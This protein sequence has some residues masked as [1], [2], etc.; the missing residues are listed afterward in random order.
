[1]LSLIDE[2]I[3]RA[4][5]HLDWN[6]L[7]LKKIIFLSSG[8]FLLAKLHNSLT[9]KK[10]IPLQFFPQTVVSSIPRT[11]C[12]HPLDGIISIVP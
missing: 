2:V 5:T 10:K 9:P 7:L 4:S 12:N 11:L 3:A 1:M 8:N 6:V